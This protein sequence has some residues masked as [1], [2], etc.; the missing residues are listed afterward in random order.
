M[1]SGANSVTR[2]ASASPSADTTTTSYP[3]QTRPSLSGLTS[4]WE[5]STSI[6]RS[7]RRVSSGGVT[8]NPLQAPG[9]RAAGRGVRSRQM[10]KMPPNQRDRNPRAAVH[11][12]EPAL[13]RAPFRPRGTEMARRRAFLAL[14]SRPGAPALERACRYDFSRSCPRRALRRCTALAGVVYKGAAERYARSRALRARGSS[15]QARSRRTAAHAP[16]C[17]ASPRRSGRAPRDP[18]RRA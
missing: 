9:Q 6:T 11:R 13:R 8:P 1:T 2:S 5:S 12:I 16:R 14:A 10:G 3:A 18:P 7:I 4:S 15:A 17:A